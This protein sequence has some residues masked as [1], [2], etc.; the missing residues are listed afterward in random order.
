MVA[1][2][3][4]TPVT[5]ARGNAVGGSE[6]GLVVEVGATWVEVETGRGPA[7]PDEVVGVGLTL[8]HP[9]RSVTTRASVDL[10]SLPG[11]FTSPA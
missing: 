5:T 10:R 9:A 2:R 11:E 8:V 7:A 3:F 1:L 6:V 4:V